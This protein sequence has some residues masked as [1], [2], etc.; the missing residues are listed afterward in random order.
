MIKQETIHCDGS[1]K[2][3]DTKLFERVICSFISQSSRSANV[4]DG[5]L[6]KKKKKR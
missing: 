3:K 5:P 2:K 6:Y 4:S 1:I